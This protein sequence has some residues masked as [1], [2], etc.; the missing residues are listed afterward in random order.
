LRKLFSIYWLSKKNMGYSNHKNEELAREKIGKENEGQS[1]IIYSFSYGVYGFMNISFKA[2]IS[3][4]PK[5]SNAFIV[6]DGRGV[7]EYAREELWN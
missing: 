4:L 1:P 6:I 5:F 3:H 7:S 2:F